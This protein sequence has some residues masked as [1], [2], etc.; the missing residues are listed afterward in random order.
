MSF[1]VEPEVMLFRNY[2]IMKLIN[3][4]VTTVRLPSSAKFLL[5]AF[6]FKY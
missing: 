2:Q 6:V 1:S 5:T 3:T 4:E